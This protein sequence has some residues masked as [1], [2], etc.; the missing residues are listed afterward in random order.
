MKK[1]VK[2]AV[3]MVILSLFIAIGFAT[4]KIVK[5]FKFGYRRGR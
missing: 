1:E 3:W 2:D 4:A 5:G